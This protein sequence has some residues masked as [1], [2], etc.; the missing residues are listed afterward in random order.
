MDK[1]HVKMTRCLD[2]NWYTLEITII[3]SCGV[4]LSYRLK[5]V[6]VMS[7][8]KWQDTIDGNDRLG[9]YPMWLNE[10]D[11]CFIINCEHSSAQ[12]D[13]KIPRHMIAT[14]LALALG[15]RPPCDHIK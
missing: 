6:P 8:E 11:D 5:Y 7:D 1:I 13:T 15:L 4:T 2:A 10:S 9:T 3:Q 14:E 12:I